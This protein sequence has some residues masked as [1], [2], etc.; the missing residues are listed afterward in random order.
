MFKD[1]KYDVAKILILIVFVGGLAYFVFGNQNSFR[2]TALVLEEGASLTDTSTVHRQLYLAGGVVSTETAENKN[3]IWTSS[4]GINW[5][6][7][8]ASAPWESREGFGFV[9]FK[10]KLWVLGG[11]TNTTNRNLDADVDT[12][13]NDVWASNDGGVTWVEV[14]AEAPW[15]KRFNHTTLVYKNKMWVIAGR[16]ITG[17]FPY[18]YNDVWYTENGT[19]WVEATSSAPFSVR[20]DHMSTVYK[21]KMWV[22]G[23]HYCCSY[24]MNDV[25]YSTDGINW[26]QSV[27][28][29]SWVDRFGGAS[30]VF[31]NKIVVLGGRNYE[32]IPEYISDLWSSSNGS[33]WSEIT[34]AP[35]WTGRV[36]HETISFNDKLWV[37]GGVQGFDFDASPAFTDNVWRKDAGADWEEVS[38]TGNP[39]IEGRSYFGLTS[40]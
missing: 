17:G 8:T 22:M 31:N 11:I 37:F 24:L 25:W 32:S 33:T 38:P 7:V 23:G 39:F 15:N 13:Y 12:I 5:D 40:N 26:T 36:G 35:E 10:D 1:P 16:P 18:F 6:L 20:F 19:D 27:E 21:N 2:S 4:D 14:L 30:T 28:S 34:P 29:A 3:D 9:Y